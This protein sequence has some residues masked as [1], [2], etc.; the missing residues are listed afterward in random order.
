MLRVTIQVQNSRKR[1][2]WYSW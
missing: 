2:T 1:N